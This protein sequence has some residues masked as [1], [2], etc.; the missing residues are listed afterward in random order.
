MGSNLTR[1]M[2]NRGD[3]PVWCAVNNNGDEQAMAAIDNYDYSNTVHISSFDSS[4]FLCDSGITW[5]YA[6]PIRKTE[7]TQAE[8]GF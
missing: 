1:A 4:F 7:I 5:R 2:L 6:V 3:K 8:V